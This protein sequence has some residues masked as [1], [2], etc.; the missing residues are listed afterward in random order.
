MAD[1]LDGGYLEREAR[2]LRRVAPVLPGVCARDAVDVLCLRPFT[3]LA[4]TVLPVVA[5]PPATHPSLLGG[6]PRHRAARRRE[7][8]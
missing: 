7:K 3:D 2:E 5:R 4:G 8:S 1:L 6:N